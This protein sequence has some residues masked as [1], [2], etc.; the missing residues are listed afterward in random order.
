MVGE[1]AGN[2]GNNTQASGSGG[3]QVVNAPA[4][5]LDGSVGTASFTEPTVDPDTGNQ[6]GIATING[7]E[8]VFNLSQNTDENGG[9]F[10]SEDGRLLIPDNIEE[11]IFGGEV[12]T[13]EVILTPFVTGTNFD[14]DQAATFNNAGFAIE[15]NRTAVDELPAQANYSGSITVTTLENI[16]NTT[17]DPDNE[18]PF[19]RSNFTATATFG[20]T[21]TL[22][23]SVTDVEDGSNVATI[24]AD[25]TGN[26]FS[27]S[28]T[29]NNGA[30]STS[31]DGGFFGPNAHDIAGSGSGVVDG[32]RTLLGLIGTRT[33]N[34]PV[35]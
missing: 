1:Q 31:L 29:D 2:N 23:G 7:E 10:I 20:Q 33:D 4:F 13:V 24:Q 9:V 14:N 34:V 32:N 28:V 18:N 17:N 27:G 26:T 19:D 12:D 22:A 35:N 16:A 5:N 30:G 6:I 11:N 21:N 25:I 8:F 15:G 3:N